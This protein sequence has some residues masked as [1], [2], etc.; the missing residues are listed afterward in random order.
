M[1]VITTVLSK[2]KNILS[3]SVKGGI[4][5]IYIITTFDIH[6]NIIITYIIRYI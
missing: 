5:K 4:D 1:S 3:N 6:N 2:I